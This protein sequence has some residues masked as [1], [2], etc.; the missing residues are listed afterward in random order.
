MVTAADLPRGLVYIHDG[1]PGFTRKKQGRKFVFFDQNGEKLDNEEDL[2]RIQSLVL[3]PAWK[4]VWISPK[5]NSHLQATG[6]D[7]KGR[8]Q[9]RYHPKWEKHSQGIKYSQLLSFGL[10]LPRLRTRYE[11]DLRRKK[12]SKEKMVAL[13][14][15]LMDESYLRIGNKIYT[16]T[17]KSYGLTTLRRKHLHFE[18]NKLTLDFTGKS[19]VQ[20]TLEIGNKK[21]VRLLRECSELPGYELFRYPTADGWKSV[22]S[23]DFNHYLNQ[24]NESGEHF[25]AKYFRTWGANCICLKRR[26]EVKELCEGTK[27]KPETTLVKLVSKD[28]GHTIAV[29]RSHYLHPDILTHCLGDDECELCLPVGLDEKAFEP[30]EIKLISLLSSKS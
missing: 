29:C 5:S 16:Q 7:E 10:Y 13:T 18:K 3:P 21:L 19:G 22:N 15:A 24:D 30:E 27:R 4:E 23:E 1:V 25:T 6:K 20:R 8:K 12:W 11:A 14:I 26:Y 2:R 28:M 17:N 9:Y